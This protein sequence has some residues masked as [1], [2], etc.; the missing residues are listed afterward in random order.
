M[1]SDVSKG[2]LSISELADKI[3]AEQPSPEKQIKELEDKCFKLNQ[4]V[5]DLTDM[6]K[7]KEAEIAHLKKLLQGTSNIVMPL[8]DEEEIIE[9]QL[10][11]L[12]Q[13]GRE[14]TLSL[15]EIKMLDLLVKNKRLTKGDVTE[16]QGKKTLPKEI[17]KKD[18][19]EL[20]AP[21]KKKKNV[22]S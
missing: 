5:L 1:K 18:L 15:P 13:A 14:R 2:S 7:D 17:G 6:V 22:P 3:Q 19:I 16:I 12:K 8:S 20:A 4:F 9:I 10:G 11:L 21:T